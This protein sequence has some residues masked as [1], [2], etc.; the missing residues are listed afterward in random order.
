[1]AGYHAGA[2][3]AAAQLV[4][5]QQSLRSAQAQVAGALTGTSALDSP[6]TISSASAA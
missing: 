3:A 6:A 4:P 1:M 2:A 5:W